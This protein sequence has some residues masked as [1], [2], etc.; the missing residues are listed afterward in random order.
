[1]RGFDKASVENFESTEV[2]TLSLF[3]EFAKVFLI[4]CVESDEEEATV[5]REILPHLLNVTKTSTYPILQHV[6]DFNLLHLKHSPSFYPFFTPANPFSLHRDWQEGHST[7]DPT[8]PALRRYISILLIN[9][10]IILIIITIIHALAYLDAYRQF[11]D[12]RFFS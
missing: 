6:R 10:I 2:E 5:K 11:S 12:T 4:V 9:I 1:L 3:C 7:A 8:P